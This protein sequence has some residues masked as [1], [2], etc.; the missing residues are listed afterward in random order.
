M[1]LSTNLRV[2]APFA[3]KL[4]YHFVHFCPVS[5]KRLELLSQKPNLNV[6]WI[7]QIE[8]SWNRWKK[9][10]PT[11]SKSKRP[12]PGLTTC[13]HVY[14]CTSLSTYLS[15]SLQCTYLPTH[16]QIFKLLRSLKN[17][18]SI[19]R[20][21]FPVSPKCLKLPFL[22]TRTK[23]FLNHSNRVFLKLST[24]DCLQGHIYINF[25]R[26]CQNLQIALKFSLSIFCY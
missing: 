19:F 8:C 20:T 23:R 14:L 2:N 24:K 9:I 26:V 25:I 3:Q 17:W 1:Y 7:I 6:F 15:T 4:T 16:L 18:F 21:F 13:P 22:K 12:T 5:P 11:K 10:Y